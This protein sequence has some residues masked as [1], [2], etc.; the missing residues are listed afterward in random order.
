MKR[1]EQSAVKIQQEFFTN[2]EKKGYLGKNTRI[3][4]AVS[5][6]VDS[7]VLLDLVRKAQKKQHFFLAVIH[8][9]HQLR[10]E[11]IQ[12]SAY[13]EEYCQLHRLSLQI[14]IWEKPAKKA[15]ETAARKFRYQMFA[16]HMKM[17]NYDY[18]MTAH[19]GDDQMET[20][21]M[22]LLRGGQLGT[23]AGIKEMQP[24]STGQLVRPLLKFSKAQLY[25]YAS[26]Q[27]LIYF[28]DYTNQKLNVQRN[29]LRHLVLPTLKK[30]NPQA[31]VHFQQFSQQVQWADQLIK[32]YMKKILTENLKKKTDT[33]CFSWK[34]L[35]KMPQE[36]RYYFLYALF[37]YVFTKTQIAIKE[38]QILL[39]L[40]QMQEPKGQWQITL[41]QDWLM[42]RVYDDVCL[43]KRRREIKKTKE[44]YQLKPNQQ[45][46]LNEN[47][48]IGLFTPEEIEKRERDDWF[49]FSHD[50]WLFPQQE[51]FVRKR[52]AGDRIRLNE[53]L[54]KKVSRYFI[55]NKISD[56]Q[57][58][59]SWVIVDENK[60]I[61]SLIPFTYSHL[62]ISVETDKI[63]YRLLYKYR[64]EAI[65][66]R[67]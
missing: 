50:L 21:L 63:H 32:K 7:M 6:G 23:Y 67:L 1:K 52:Q 29:R 24:F 17:G 53:K 42:Q 64:K 3:L 60:I 14:E 25:Q 18:L 39:I 46:I 12:E 45:I 28:E 30:E 54:N 49:E 66:R 40:Q 36:E 56:S 11:S 51:L 61:Y 65:G 57:R 38:Q 43:V 20:I 55:D 31:M 37:D 10:K 16:K 5:G 41:G 2:G 59:C 47:E 13:L 22:K 26:E 34:I 35:E 4:L 9:N 58:K 33:F 48:W 19:H 44:Y 15:I 8:I 62:S 27:A